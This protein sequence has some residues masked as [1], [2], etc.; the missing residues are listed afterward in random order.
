MVTLNPPLSAPARSLTERLA[1]SRYAEFGVG[2]P[3][4]PDAH[5]K[6]ARVI[7]L[8]KAMGQP[9]GALPGR[10]HFDPGEARDLLSNIWL[11]DVVADDPRRFR[12][13]LV[14]GAL[15]EAGASLRKGQ[16]FTDI[17]TP[18]EGQRNLAFFSNLAQTKRIDWRRGPSM[19]GYMEHVKEL[20]RVIMPMAENG[21]VV[22]MFLCLTVFYG[23]DGSAW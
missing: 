15:I 4:P 23:S 3:A 1:Q 13:R 19:L 8:W 10:Q 16:F 5:P 17:G 18:E 21:M 12:A 2:E 9:D 22:D 11:L 14:G 7:E 6:I 20:E